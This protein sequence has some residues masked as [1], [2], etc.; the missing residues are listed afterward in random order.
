MVVD[1]AEQ[2]LY[3][4]GGTDPVGEHSGMYRYDIRRGLWSELLCVVCPLLLLERAQL[5]TLGS[6]V[7]N[8]GDGYMGLQSRTGHCMLWNAAR[9]EILIFGG[10]HSPT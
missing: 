8:S 7:L 5:L 1:E 6:I 2:A 3:V 4:Y 10:L 9:R